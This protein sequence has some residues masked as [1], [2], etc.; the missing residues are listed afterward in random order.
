MSKFN[1][2]CVWPGT[3]L[4]EGTPQDLVDFFQKEFTAQIVT[5]KHIID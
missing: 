5:G 2:L 4:G 1:Q 3:V